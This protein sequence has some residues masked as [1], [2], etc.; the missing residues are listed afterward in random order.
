MYD[1][2]KSPNESINIA[3]KVL[4]NKYD[5]IGFLD[6]F[7]SFTDILYNQAKLKYKYKGKKAN[8]TQGRLSINAL[9]QSTI[10]KIEQINY[11]D[12][13]LYRKV[14]DAID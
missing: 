5:I 10:S 13:A 12:I 7:S 9:E 3:F 6:D 11:L 1:A 2:E 4:L 14:R 8:V